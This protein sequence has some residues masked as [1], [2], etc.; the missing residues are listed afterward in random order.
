MSRKTIAKCGAGVLAAL[1]ATCGKDTSPESPG[2]LNCSVSPTS[3]EAPLT[4]TFSAQARDARD[5]DFHWVFS[6]GTAATAATVTRTLTKG[7]S[8]SGRVTLLSTG[9]S[10]TTATIDLGAKVHVSCNADPSV[11]VSPDDVHFRATPDGGNGTFTYAWNFGDGATSADQNPVHRY[12]TPGTYP[13]T[14]TATSGGQSASCVTS[15]SAFKTRLKVACDA[16]PTSGTPPLTVNFSANASGDSGRYEYQWSFGDGGTSRDPSPSHTYTT[17]DVFTA[18]VAVQGDVSGGFCEQEISLGS[19]CGDGK[20]QGKEACDDGNKTSG[21]GCSSCK[22]DPGFA[23]SGSPSKCSATCGDGKLV[24]GEQCDDGNT[25]NSDGCSA[26]CQIETGF[27]CGGAPSACSPICGDGK[28]LGAEAC[29]DG[30]TTNADGC[31]SACKIEHGFACSGAPSACSSTCGDGL[32]ASDEACDDNNTT[33]GD[34]CSSTCK[35]EGGFTCTGEPSV[36]N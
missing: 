16:T 1:L 31:S 29:D 2:A 32:V 11:I 33:N 3:G 26:S 10:C 27:T 15:V 5:A 30:N 25:S 23:C 14:V 22:I 36:C 6:D 28:V 35:V 34:G 19:T 18:R 4:V 21:D 17:I 8:L 7:G 12:Q 13:V 24:G 20:V 9:E